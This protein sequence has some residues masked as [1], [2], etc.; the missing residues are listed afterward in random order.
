LV[1]ELLAHSN[2]PEIFC[3]DEEN[4]DSEMKRAVQA[5]R[6]K[7]FP[8]TLIT[9]FSLIPGKVNRINVI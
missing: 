7:T 9:F 1:L 4:N 6:A 3:W 2:D 8:L 5:K